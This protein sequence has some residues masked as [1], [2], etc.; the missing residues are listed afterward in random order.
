M[1]PAAGSPVSSI[2]I[3]S[4]LAAITLGLI[5]LNWSILNWSIDISP[6]TPESQAIGVQQTRQPTSPQSTKSRP[7]SNLAEALGR[8]LFNPERRPHVAQETA[9][10]PARPINTMQ[11][12]LEAQF[13]GLT[14]TAAKGKR[15]LIRLPTERD[16]VWLA[17]GD[18]LSG[19]KLRD[20]RADDVVFE[21]SGQTQIILFQPK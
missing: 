13:V 20:I 17:V 7:E 10:A 9:R 16:G 14:S 12:P 8:P 21:N 15:I 11:P 19:W 3:N 6:V 1:K 18:S 5:A 4:V 2:A